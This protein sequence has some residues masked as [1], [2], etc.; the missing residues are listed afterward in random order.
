MLY[1]LVYSLSCASEFSLKEKGIG[2]ETKQDPSSY[3]SLSM[4]P[5]YCLQKKD[6]LPGLP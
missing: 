6:V 5:I 1:V 2:C 4:S 3:K